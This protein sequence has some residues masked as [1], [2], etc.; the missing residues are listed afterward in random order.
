LR[1]AEAERLPL[2]GALETVNLAT[3]LI[4]N[5]RYESDFATATAFQGAW[6]VYQQRQWG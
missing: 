1:L 2:Q 5:A 6:T 3:K 4:E